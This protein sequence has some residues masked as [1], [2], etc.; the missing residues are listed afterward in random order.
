MPR[1]AAKLP[2][3]T[4]SAKKQTGCYCGTCFWRSSRNRRRSAGATYPRLTK[5]WTSI[6]VLLKGN[7]TL[8]FFLTQQVR[9]FQ[10]RVI[11]LSSPT[12]D[13]QQ[14]VNPNADEEILS[15]PPTPK[16]RKQGRPLFAILNDMQER[17][18]EQQKNQTDPQPIMP[19]TSD[20][21]Q[22][23]QTSES[24]SSSAHLPKTVER[25]NSRN[26]SP[27][28]SPNKSNNPTNT[29]SSNS[30]SPQASIPSSP[31]NTQNNNSPLNSPHLTLQSNSAYNSSTNSTANSQ[32]EV[33]GPSPRPLSEFPNR[34]R[35]R[36][37][38]SP[39]NPSGLF[40]F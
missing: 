16:R 35:S 33:E 1:Y 7:F 5:C 22:R 23:T 40:H 29:N 26:R 25:R 11:T 30:S 38:R 13:D 6:D 8:Y 32:E 15:E 21:E 12:Q 20:V 28:H 36:I 9:K 2:N 10:P 18:E 37:E 14:T 3:L 19:Q 17:M 27:L 24:P 31:H 39:S 4:L 34:Q